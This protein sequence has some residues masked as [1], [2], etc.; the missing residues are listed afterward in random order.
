V[1][2]QSYYTLVASLPRLAHFEAAG[3]VDVEVTEFIPGTLSRCFGR[4]PS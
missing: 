2:G 4:K 3:F 1:A